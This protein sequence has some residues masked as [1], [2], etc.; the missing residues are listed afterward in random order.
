MSN[1][2]VRYSVITSQ[3]GN[4]I[5]YNPSGN[6]QSGTTSMENVKIL[7]SHRQNKTNSSFQGLFDPVD[8][9]VG[10]LILKSV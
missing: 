8:A 5:Y 6:Q 4:H 10:L 2:Q 7:H 9:P 1:D 3:A